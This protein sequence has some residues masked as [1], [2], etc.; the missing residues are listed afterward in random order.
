ML[1]YNIS[2]N[3]RSFARMLC[4]EVDHEQ[5]VRLPYFPFEQLLIARE[6][7]EAVRRE[8]KKRTL[9]SHIHCQTSVLPYW[10]TT[11]MVIFGALRVW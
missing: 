8:R 9:R 7:K 2:V 4:I 5:A 10:R 6:K 3:E 1:H 11:R